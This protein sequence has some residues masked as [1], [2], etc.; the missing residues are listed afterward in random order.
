MRQHI[1]NNKSNHLSVTLVVP[2]AWDGP[3]QEDTLMLPW[4]K[5]F[6]YLSLSHIIALYFFKSILF[7]ELRIAAGR[8]YSVLNPAVICLHEGRT[9]VQ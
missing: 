3:S 5:Y 1:F 6:L 2:K 7:V 9:M 8:S 4:G